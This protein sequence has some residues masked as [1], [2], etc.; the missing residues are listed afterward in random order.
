MKA[1]LKSRSLV[2]RITLKAAALI[3]AFMVF[4]SGFQVWSQYRLAR[5]QLQDRSSR[6]LDLMVNAM[7]KPLWEMDGQRLSDLV[8]GLVRHEDI[9]LK[10]EVTS[11]GRVMAV[12]N[13]PG[14]SRDSD[15]LADNGSTFTVESPITIYDREIGHLTMIISRYPIHEEVWRTLTYRTSSMAVVVLTLFAALLWLLRK[16]V[17]APLRQLGR[18]AS[19][20]AGGQ[21]DKSI[22]WGNDDEIGRL[23]K[24]LDSMR[25]SLDDTIRKLRN[26]QAS[27]Q[28]YSKIL[29]NKV[30]ERTRQLQENLNLLQEA[31]KAAESA[32]HAKSEFLANMSHEIRTPLSVVLGMM[33]VVMESELTPEQ[34]TRLE[35]VKSSV[36][37][38]HVLLNDILDFSKIEAGKLSL[39]AVDFDIRS[40][41]AG[42]EALL[43]AKSRDKSLKLS[44]TI[45]DD[46][47]GR[48]CGDP[49]R[50]RQVLLN[51]G[52]NAVKFTDEG[53]I[54]IGAALREDLDD[55][56]VLLFSVSDTGIGIHPDKLG[57]VFERFSQADSS[58]STKH[59]GT[60]LGLAISSQLV[61]AMGGEMWV[62]SELGKGSTFHFTVRLAK[63]RFQEPAAE[64]RTDGSL[65]PDEFLGVKVLLVEDNL[66]NQAVARR[67]LS[68]LGCEVVIVSNG[69]EAV[70]A[71][72]L[73]RFDLILMDLRM[74]EMD[75]FEATRL[76]RAKETSGRIPIIAQTAHAFA[77]YRQQC[78]DAG[79]DEHI[80][81]PFNTSQLIPLLRRFAHPSPQIT[82]T[83][84]H[85]GDTSG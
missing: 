10:V 68:K 6:I 5:N 60:G 59:G 22:S 35:I 62:E 54:S 58:I 85:S 67:I 18:A 77:E 31:K 70:E 21:L 23:F 47:P 61:N 81:K 25:A 24:D 76:I 19:E 82:A 2:F 7:R 40:L 74:P 15:H 69:R 13:Q 63:C 42:T 66:L 55:S 73:R 48:L 52:N 33:D 49:N 16:D 83:A 30:D 1:S 53:E 12:R 37:A 80:A 14:F 56:V 27:L 41:L 38:L 72:G 29:E 9:V 20:I 34:R 17:F 46:V 8:D 51:L 43:A 71:F 78:L 4:L 44:C 28:E 57:L 11:G 84:N 75:G 36:D 3:V 79:M 32:T 64:T 45:G 39:E 50:L 26:S 65:P